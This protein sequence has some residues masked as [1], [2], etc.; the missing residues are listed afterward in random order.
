M[1]QAV[2]S[3]DRPMR[4]ATVRDRLTGGRN[5]KLHAATEEELGSK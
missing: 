5:I 3:I 4:F 1:F 2:S